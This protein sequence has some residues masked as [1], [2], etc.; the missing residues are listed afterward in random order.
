[1]AFGALSSGIS[2]LRSFAKGMEVIGNN[3][4]N[5]NT[6]SFKGSRV[7]YSETFNQVLTQSAPSPQDGQGSN[8]T[9]SQVGLGVQVDS[10][11]GLFHQGGIST[12]N[13]KTD[14][15]ISGEGFFLVS[16]TRN[17]GAKFATRGGDFRIDDQG[18]LVTTEGF[19][20]QGSNDGAIGYNVSVDANGNW[21]FAKNPD[22]VSGTIEPSVLGDISL[23]FDRSQA[24]EV[25][26]PYV[27]NGVARNSIY[28]TNNL[29]ASDATGNLQ[30]DGAHNIGGTNTMELNPDGTISEVPG[31][32]TFAQDAVESII[33][34]RNQSV[35]TPDLVT[36]A[37]IKAAVSKDMFHAIF[38]ADAGTT[39]LSGTAIT[40]LM[41]TIN[42]DH[43]G[44]STDQANNVAAI[45]ALIPSGATPAETQQ[46]AL[47]RVNQVRNDKAPDI[48]NFTIDRE[49]MINISL[50]DGASFHKGQIMLVDFNDT[51][52]LIREGRNLYSGFGAAGLKGLSDSGGSTSAD[53][54][55][56]ALQVGG[57]G[58]LGEIQQ[59][60]IELSNVDLTEE[61]ANM[62]TTQRGFQA[63]SRIITVSDDI[64]QE[65]VNLKR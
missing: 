36:D 28:Y 39:G 65:V 26:G 50:S 63:G 22:A 57:R 10:I 41:A 20:V 51:S 11:K 13:S 49:G 21:S 53:V 47:N 64:L 17:Q 40:D 45:Q 30:W 6:T 33:A 23:A 9:A 7:S 56:S 32:H 5:V 55:L 37:D 14:L 4:A 44:T 1:M 19:R 46:S 52:A 48:T 24:D 2:A 25:V 29:I 3:I 8:V 61:F 18:N 42:L 27:P 43:L 15:A 62:I 34:Q 31:W 12:T 60:A 38:S 59:G 16:D 54:S 58:G 35:T